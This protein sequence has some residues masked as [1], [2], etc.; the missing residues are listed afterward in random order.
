MQALD[1]YPLDELKL[2]Y[3]LLHE[4]LPA[5]LELMDSDLLTDLQRLLQQAAKA[6]GVDVSL[7]AQ[8]AAW[9]N[10]GVQLKGV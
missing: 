5:N 3:R 1:Q 4:A 2:I 9:L 7:H 10:G 6:D 8:W